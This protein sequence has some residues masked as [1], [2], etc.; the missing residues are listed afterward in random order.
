MNT[1][2]PSIPALCGA[3]SECTRRTGDPHSLDLAEL[4]DKGDFDPT[5]EVRLA[6][7]VKA[8]LRDMA[9]AHGRLGRVE[10]R[11]WTM[12]QVPL[13][14]VDELTEDGDANVKWDRN[15]DVVEDPEARRKVGDLSFTERPSAHGL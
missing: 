9:P 7:L 12:P 1:P 15:G 6:Q 13:V 10:E 5:F 3:R 2:P 14:V 8:V 11:V 4:I